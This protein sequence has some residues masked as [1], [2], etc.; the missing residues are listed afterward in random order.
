MPTKAQSPV[1]ACKNPLQR[2]VY[3]QLLGT[4]PTSL[5]RMMTMPVYHAIRR[6]LVGRS[7]NV[8]LLLHSCLLRVE[9]KIFPGENAQRAQG[10]KPGCGQIHVGDWSTHVCVRSTPE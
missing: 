1:R 7:S 9:R 6:R 3:Q 10:G 2:C 8:T 5:G 4:V